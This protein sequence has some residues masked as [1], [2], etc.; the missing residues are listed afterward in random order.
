MD[1]LNQRI[2]KKLI[3]IGE[4]IKG[5]KPFM[6]EHLRMV[7]TIIVTI[8]AEHAQALKTLKLR[9]LSISAIAKNLN[10]SR[11][12]LYNHN[13]LLKR[14]ITMSEEQVKN[15]DP[16]FQI[17]YL[18]EKVNELNETIIQLYDRDIREQIQNHLV[19]ELTKKLQEKGK[20]IQRLESRIRD[21]SKQQNR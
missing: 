9:D 3:L 13:Q 7:E 17:D 14:Y 5:I 2:E 11:T 19:H 12:T 8:E 20:E 1:K 16:F 6:I 18:K 10:M 21:L 15:N 4:D